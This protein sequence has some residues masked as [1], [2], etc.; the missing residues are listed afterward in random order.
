MEVVRRHGDT[1]TVFREYPD[2]T[3]EGCL[4][5]RQGDG[6]WSPPLPI[7]LVVPPERSRRAARPSVEERSGL[8]TIRSSHDITARSLQATCKSTSSRIRGRV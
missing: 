2:G 3:C 4:F 6:S 5:Y 7:G 1:V 8:A